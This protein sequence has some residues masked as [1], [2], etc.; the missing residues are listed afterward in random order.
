MPLPDNQPARI[1]FA[2]FVGD[3]RWSGMGKWTHSI[4]DCLSVIGHRP[5][6]WFANDFPGVEQWHRWGVLLYPVALAWRVWKHRTRFDAVIVHEA[7]GF[8]CCLMRRL[9]F[10]LPPIVAMCHNVESKLFHEMVGFSAQGLAVVPWASRLK[11]PLLRL[12]QSDGTIRMADH[13]ICL[14]SVDRDYLVGRL[15]VSADRIT[16]ITNG[17][18]AEHIPTEPPLEGKRV[19]FVGGWLDV[20]GRRVLPALWTKI[21]A[22]TPRAS[23]TILGAGQAPE[24]VLND[25]SPEDR[26]SVTVIPRVTGQWEMAEHYSQHDVY[27]MASLSEGSSL[28]LLEALAAGIPVVATRVGGN[29]DIIAHNQ[30]GLLFAPTDIEEGAAHVSRL[31][32]DHGAALRLR[33]AGRQTAQKL[34]WRQTTG[35]LLAA[36]EKAIGRTLETLPVPES[37]PQGTAPLR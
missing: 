6:T 35:A 13:V 8:W 3:N 18:A 21:R 22:T 10:P 19:L 14:S 7:S 23:L 2:S 9:G 20:K 1:L 36:C 5:S 34:D 32:E 33:D 16:R 12:W 24:I 29:G 25:F 27:L 28:A 26:A 17:V 4:A 15:H 11:A 37:S 30:N 31:L